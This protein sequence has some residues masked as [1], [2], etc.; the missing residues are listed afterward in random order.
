MA[1]AYQIQYLGCD[2]PFPNF[3]SLE[4]RA[5]TMTDTP[6]LGDL[7]TIWYAYCTFNGPAYRVADFARATLLPSI[8]V[9]A[10]QPG[11]A[12]SYAANATSNGLNAVA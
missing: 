1:E 9:P 3:L 7:C 11:P 8:D 6:L 10:A 5:A 2:R 12:H 4:P